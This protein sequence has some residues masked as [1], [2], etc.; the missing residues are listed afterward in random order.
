MGNNKKIVVGLS[1]GMD[2]STLLGFLLNEG[3]EVHACL[4]TYGAKH[5][6]YENEA[7]EKVGD[8]YK[9]NYPG[10]L[11]VYRFDFSSLT[12]QFKSNLLLGGGDIP[13]GHYNDENM[14]KTVVPGRN[15]IFSSIMAGLAESL[16][17]G[18]VAL[19]VHAGDHH[20]YPDCRMEFT[21]SLD[22]TLFLSSDRQVELK[23]PFERFTKRDILT[24]GYS[25]PVD[26]PYYYTRT[27]YKDQYYS[28]GKCG[29][30]QERLEAFR[31]IGKDDPIEYGPKSL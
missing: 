19:G 20:I 14:R 10:K 15:L 21:K 9:R 25:L 27:C 22:T 13:E 26:V 11:I 6:K 24:L 28:C 23:T 16:G 5:N 2:S 18:Y 1:G 4:F 7:A 3:H 8:Y 17:A 12:S 31:L 30:C 29:S